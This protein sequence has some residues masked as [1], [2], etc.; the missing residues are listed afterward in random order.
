MSARTSFQSICR[1]VGQNLS[2]LASSKPQPYGQPFRV[3]FLQAFVFADQNLPGS[4][5]FDL[6]VGPY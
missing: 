3:Q 6:S 2:P 5:T 1:D 4:G